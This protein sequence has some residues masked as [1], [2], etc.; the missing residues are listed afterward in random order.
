MFARTK[1]VTEAK[2]PEDAVT[3]EIPAM[4]P[5]DSK[6]FLD[7]LRTVHF[8]LLAVC[9]AAVVIISSPS[10]TRIMK[11]SGQLDQI[12]AVTTTENW[13]KKNW[14][15][16]SAEAE[17]NGTGKGDGHAECMGETSDLFL[18]AG[19]EGF[20]AVVTRKWDVEYKEI[21][22]SFGVAAP[23]S[24]PAP[25]TLGQFRAVWNSKGT[26]YCPPTT[27][28]QLHTGDPVDTW[29]TPTNNFGHEE[30]QHIKVL[31]P[32]ES[33]KPQLKRKKFV[34]VETEHLPKGE[35]TEVLSRGKKHPMDRPPTALI[36]VGPDPQ[37]YAIPTTR[38]ARKEF[39]N[40]KVRSQITAAFPGDKWQDVDFNEAFRELNQVATQQDAFG[41]PFDQ[42]KA[43]ISRQVNDAKDAFEAFGIKFPVYGTTRWA[44][45]LILCIQ[46]YLWLHLNE[47]SRRNFPPGDIAWIGMYA[48]GAAKFLSR[49]TMLFVPVLV[50]LLLCIQQGL[51]HLEEP[52]GWNKAQIR[53]KT[54]DIVI[55]SLAVAFSAFLAA[56]TAR[57][58][59]R[60][61]TRSEK[62]S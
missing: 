50:V 41:V 37:E 26:L 58:Y 38:D 30:A 57:S 56:L 4:K 19:H 40:I 62:P 22:V 25:Q 15:Q 55:C 12:I 54:A 60:V 31:S 24:I 48:G 20:R 28:F 10:P 51:V 18:N 59:Q 44:V 39:G 6:D 5:S 33:D 17:A 42:L 13:N 36:Q 35:D 46:A 14:I 32:S 7:Q 52:V 21:A 45:F 3:Q 2:S 29:Y 11:A 9:L 61:K 34:W 16:A 27:K 43:S 47:Y 49:A 23:P 53:P 8:T 1:R